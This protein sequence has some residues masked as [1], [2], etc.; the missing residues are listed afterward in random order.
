MFDIKPQN[1]VKQLSFNK[2]IKWQKKNSGFKE[3]GERAWAL[4]L[5]KGAILW[6]K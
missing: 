6:V 2:K 4:K 5:P 3:V 1:S